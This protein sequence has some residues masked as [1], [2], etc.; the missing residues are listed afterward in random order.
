MSSTD[1][2]TEIS[3]TIVL[4]E[5][6]SFKIQKVHSYNALD[7]PFPHKHSYVRVARFREL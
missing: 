1:G 3:T 4:N 6:V 5:N 7:N 2:G